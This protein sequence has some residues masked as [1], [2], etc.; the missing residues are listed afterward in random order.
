MNSTGQ[1]WVA[2]SE[3]ARHPTC[4]APIRVR[5]PSVPLHVWSRWWSPGV[6]AEGLL[7]VV[8]AEQEGEAGQ[9][10]AQ[11]GEVVAAENRADGYDARLT[12]HVSAAPAHDQKRAGVSAAPLPAPLRPITPTGVA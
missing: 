8:V 12:S 11:L 3:P 4:Q 7:A 6:V 10:G 1:E 2:G 9:V 5:R